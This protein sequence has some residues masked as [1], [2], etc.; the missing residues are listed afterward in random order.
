MSPFARK[1][2]KAHPGAG[3]TGNLAAPSP[4]TATAGDASA[5]LWW[6]Y[7][8]NATGYDM[9]FRTSPAGSW[10][11]WVYGGTITHI[12]IT[13]LTNGT[14]YDFQVRAKNSS[15][16]SP[17]S[18]VVSG[19]TPVATPSTGGGL[20]ATFTTTLVNNS[21]TNTVYA[22]VVGMDPNNGLR[23]SLVQSSGNGLYAPPNP[24]ADHTPIPVDCAIPLNGIGAAGKDI[25]LPRLISGRIMISYDAKLQLFTNSNGGFVMPSPV[26]PSDPN[27][28]TQWT[29]CEF[30]FD[31]TQ[32]YGNI[33]FVD[34]LS[35]PLAFN[36][37]VSDGTGTQ[38]VPGLPD[39]G[40]Q[41]VA[42]KLLAQK[43]ADGG[44]WDKC[45]VYNNSS[46]IRI[47]SPNSTVQVFPTAFTGYLSSYV[48]AVWAT[49]STQPLTIDTQFTWGQ[50]SGQVSAGVLDF[51]G[52]LTYAK[53]TSA[54]VF[55]CSTGPFTTG[56]DESGNISARL[57][58]AFNRTTL[59]VNNV[60]PTN[61]N[62][63]N[64]Y[65]TEQRTNHYAR[66]VHEV[67]YGDLGYAFP[68]DDVHPAGVDFEGR[69]QSGSPN[70]WTITVGKA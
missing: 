28:N 18:A 19:M 48:D 26:N 44:D 36:L 65:Y 50:V 60:Q 31:N 51:G 32:L 37:T 57:A 23:W 5:T 62:P 34:I 41:T 49:Y 45:L 64:F 59:L 58:A 4:V 56:N 10:Q 16:V 43:A 21:T 61:E 11:A 15:G 7:V 17:W 25:T 66:I 46:L 67:V 9:Q 63:S 2:Q 12:S 70:H 6:T 22:Y 1:L 30:T 52:G 3:Q 8:T 35:I 55:S 38:N 68:Y 33:S 69:I 53:P 40:M 24:S 47:L 39:Y 13:S 54:D 14:A 42:T 29:F 20:P 27:N